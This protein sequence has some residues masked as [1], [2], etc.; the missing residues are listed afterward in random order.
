MI[1]RPLHVSCRAVKAYDRCS[2]S[3]DFGAS[4]QVPGFATLPSHEP[5]AAAHELR[6]CVNEIRVTWDPANYALRRY[7]LDH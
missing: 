4:H 7:R 5:A 3:T 2:C 1:L 6:R